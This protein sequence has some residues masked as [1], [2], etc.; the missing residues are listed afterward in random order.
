MLEYVEQ[1]T[2]DATQISPAFHDRLRAVGFDDR[3]DPADHA[4]RLVVQLHQPRRRRAGGRANV[5][6]GHGFFAENSHRRP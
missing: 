3:G 2:S 5:S 6:R 4:D 1:I